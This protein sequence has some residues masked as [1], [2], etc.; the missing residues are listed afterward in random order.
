MDKLK[1]N[2]NPNEALLTKQELLILKLVSKGCSNKQIAERLF[3]S[4]ETV[5]THLKN[6]YKKLE[7]NNR[8]SALI[9][10]ASDKKYH[11]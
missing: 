6:I 9:K 5:K 3:I 11:F 10:S 7:V 4:T 8:I 2:K 1:Y